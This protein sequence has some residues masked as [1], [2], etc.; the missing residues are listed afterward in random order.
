MLAAMLPLGIK[1][2]KSTPGGAHYI[3]DYPEYI[4]GLS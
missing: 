4:R 1:C 3:G 2:V